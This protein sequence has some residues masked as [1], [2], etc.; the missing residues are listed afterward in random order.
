MPTRSTGSERDLH[1]RNGRRVPGSPPQCTE[2]GRG[3]HSRHRRWGCLGTKPGALDPSAVCIPRPGG[4]VGASPGPPDPG[5]ICTPGN[6]LQDSRVPNPDK[7]CT[8]RDLRWVPLGTESRQDLHLDC[9]VGAQVLTPGH[10]IRA[11]F[12]PPGMPGWVPDLSPR[13]APQTRAHRAAH[14]ASC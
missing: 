12:A 10:R 13:V 6:A 2:S 8:R 11:G 1:P 3:F 4:R 14:R 7:V 9:R 5:R